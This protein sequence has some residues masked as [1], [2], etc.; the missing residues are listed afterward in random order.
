MIS[1][2]LTE[3]QTLAQ[4]AAAQFA[5]D[6]ARPAARAAEESKNFQKCCSAEPG[7]WVWPR[8]PLRVS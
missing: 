6:E 4:A 1:F 7:N 8:P 3:D 5:A 2:A